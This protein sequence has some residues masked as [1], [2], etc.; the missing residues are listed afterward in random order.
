MTHEQELVSFGNYLLSKERTE[1]VSSNPDP[2]M[3]VIVNE[4]L[5]MVSDADVEDWRHRVQVEQDKSSMY[6]AS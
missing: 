2:S 6:H 5:S 3:Q 4:R 1:R